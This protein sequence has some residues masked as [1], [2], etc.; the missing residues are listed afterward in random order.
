MTPVS[1]GRAGTLASDQAG[2]MEVLD[3]VRQSHERSRGYGL[4]ETMRPDYSVLGEP[5]L[6]LKREQ[7][8]T[9]CTHAL[10]VIETLYGQIANTHSMVV[11]TDSQGLI[12]H[13][14]GDDDFLARADRVA[15]RAG[16]LWSEQQQGT[17]AV[18]TT[19]ASGD[20][21]MILGDQHYLRA[22]QFLACS[23]VPILDP[24][25]E[26]LG[27]LDV[28][29][30]CRGHSRH[31][32]ALAKMSAQ[33]I[34]NHLF[35][36]A[37]PEAMR[38][39]F[40]GRPEFIGTLMEGIAAFRADGRFLSA[41]RSAQFQFGLPLASLKAHSLS[42]LL[43]VSCGE[44]IDL[45]RT[46]VSAPGDRLLSL[47]LPSGVNV[48]ASVD[49]RRSTSVAFTTDATDIT[50]VAARKRAPEPQAKLSGLRYLMTGDSQVAALV[51]RV[52]KVIG[53]N[54][55]ILIGGET[56]TGKEVLASAVHRDSPQCDG[57]FVAVDCASIPDTLIESELFGYEEGAFTGA[58][59]RGA[60][61]KILQADGGTLFLDEIGDM[62]LALQSRLLRV[63]QERTVT[64]LGSSRSVPVDFALICATNRNLRECVNSGEF[65]EDLYYRIN[66]LLVTLPP[67]RL[68]TDLAVTVEKILRAERP[69][70][71]VIRV[72]PEVLEAFTQH[73]W[74]GNFRQLANVLRTACAMLDDDETTILR[75][76]LPEDFF[77]REGATSQPHSKESGRLDDLALSAV[78]AALDTHGGNVSAAARMLGVSR[79]TLYRKMAALGELRRR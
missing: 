58:S 54:I 38:V 28:S 6:L 75:D 1:L 31:T 37:F 53:K 12:L 26:L 56:G 68:R 24:F 23:S 67:L 14:L 48:F 34:E 50:D 30:D 72:S 18:G 44:L 64:P 73:G 5:D 22:N 51:E 78:S 42:S 43:N 33:M 55:P 61:G 11:L 27:V 32:M 41:N 52:R 2:R 39:H 57:P 60:C 62:P 25:G 29:G 47:R 17:N 3:I 8:R 63:L 15:L 40:H 65:R 76:H 35:T 70:G 69:G 36:S 7:N 59:K 71:P 16:A 21:T 4:S 74:P 19:I 9:L 49:F 10:P 13:S 46:G 45:M 77:E 20:A 79:N 66:G